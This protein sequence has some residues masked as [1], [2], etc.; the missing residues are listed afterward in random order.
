[1]RSWTKLGSTGMLKVLLIDKTSHYHNIVRLDPSRFSPEV[2]WA[3]HYSKIETALVPL[4]NGF[5]QDIYCVTIKSSDKKH[6]VVFSFF[7]R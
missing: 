4:C 6:F 2:Y 5:Y 7:F 3:G 1:M